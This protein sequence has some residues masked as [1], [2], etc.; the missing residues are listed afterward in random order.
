[1]PLGP[2][3]KPLTSNIN[4]SEGDVSRVKRAS[5]SEPS[6]CFSK[7]L[8]PARTRSNSLLSALPAKRQ[9][10]PRKSISCGSGSF[11][12][13]TFSPSAE[14][15]KRS[16][17]KSS[18]PSASRSN[19]SA[20]V[21]AP[22]WSISL[23]GTLKPGR[24][25]SISAGSASISRYCF[26]DSN[27]SRLKNGSFEGFI[28]MAAEM[29]FSVIRSSSEIGA[30]KVAL[31][32]KSSGGSGYLVFRKKCGL[33]SSNPIVVRASVVQPWSSR[34]SVG[35]S[36]SSSEVRT[37]SKGAGA[38]SSGGKIVAVSSSK[39]DDSASSSP[40]S[41]RGSSAFDSANV[42][43][44]VATSLP[45]NVEKR[46]VFHC[47]SALQTTIDQCRGRGTSTAKP[48]SVTVHAP[49]AP[50]GW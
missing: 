36:S 31:S 2:M 9:L 15:A 28:L 30:D 33:P 35:P 13:I 5:I 3:A 32:L 39:R 47:S 50:E 6:A 24:A 25:Q 19:F 38:G 26:H 8:S 34:A 44:A 22:R 16:Q 46:P 4:G 12:L 14:N 21:M 48:G 18:L 10:S 1:M 29:S 49:A 27:P 41:R 40:C 37:G 11:R 43:Y 42:V 23:S 45:A 7:K 17:L 20:P